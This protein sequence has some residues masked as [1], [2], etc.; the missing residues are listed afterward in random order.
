MVDTSYLDIDFDG[1]DKDKDKDNCYAR[2]DVINIGGK[3]IVNANA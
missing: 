2:V 3:T 1:N